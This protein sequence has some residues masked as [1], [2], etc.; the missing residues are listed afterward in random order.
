MCSKVF[1]L[2]NPYQVIFHMV[3]DQNYKINQFVYF[4]HI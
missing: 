4:N 3:L 2:I 1:V